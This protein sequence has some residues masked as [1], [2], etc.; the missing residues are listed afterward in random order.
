M[1]QVGN[2]ASEIEDRSHFGA[3][4]IVGSPLILGYDLTN[5]TTAERVWPIVSNVEAISINQQWAGHPALVHN[6]SCPTSG[7]ISNVGAG[8]L[9]L[10]C[11]S[12]LSALELELD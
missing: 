11:V 12:T 1:L 5:Q 2:L 4:C 6:W 3:W 7:A 8:C 9:Q 10:W